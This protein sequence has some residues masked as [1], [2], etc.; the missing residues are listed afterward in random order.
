MTSTDDN[1]HEIS[2]ILSTV[3]DFTL[4][5][6]KGKDFYYAEVFVVLIFLPFFF[7]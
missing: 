3:N 7:L 4:V 1:L 2:L 5:D 6:L